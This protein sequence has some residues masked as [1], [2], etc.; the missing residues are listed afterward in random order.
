MQ[1]GD[2]VHGRGR[3]I[4]AHS[5]FGSIHLP[6]AIRSLHKECLGLCASRSNGSVLYN[7]TRQFNAVPA[8]CDESCMQKIN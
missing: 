6:L 2:G 5:E 8:R 4:A 1:G 3:G 7:P